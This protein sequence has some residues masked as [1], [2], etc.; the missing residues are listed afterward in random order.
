[1]PG[2]DNRRLTE[3]QQLVLTA[4]DEYTIAPTARRVA[5]RLDRPRWRAKRW[6]RRQVHGILDRLE[7]R[8]LVRGIEQRAGGRGGERWETVWSLTDAGKAALTAAAERAAQG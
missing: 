7:R 3:K 2:A 5:D 1:M 6:H 4:L 8:G